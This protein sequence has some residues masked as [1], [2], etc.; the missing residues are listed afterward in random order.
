[1]IFSKDRNGR[2]MENVLDFYVLNPVVATFYSP[3]MDGC[4]ASVRPV[5]KGCRSGAGCLKGSFED[6]ILPKMES[7]IYEIVK[8]I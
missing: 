4:S 1:M 7:R 6:T 2:T 5:G 8:K 3:P